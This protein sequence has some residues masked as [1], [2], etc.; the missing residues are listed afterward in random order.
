MS[1]DI[2]GFYVAY[3][4][5]KAGQGLAVLIFR[6]GRIVG[7][8]IAGVLFDGEYTESADGALSISLLAKTPPNV[9][10]IQGGTSGPQG[11][12][13]ALNFEMP[14]DFGSLNFIRIDGPRGPVNTK[15]VRLRGLNE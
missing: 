8:D 15:L 11:L 4:S 9:A 3:L 6:K 12:E 2:E 7:A 1:S 5:A 13:T 14:R 10:L